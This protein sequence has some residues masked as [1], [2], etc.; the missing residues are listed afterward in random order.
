MTRLRVG[1]LAAFY[2]LQSTWVLHAGFDALFPR[3]AAVVTPDA[4]CA[5][6]C[7]CPEDVRQRG[8][9]C[10]DPLAKAAAPKSHASAFDVARCSGMDLAMAHAVGLPALLDVP[11]LLIV[12]AA[13]RGP[14]PPGLA[15]ALDVPALPLEKVPVA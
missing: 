7:G 13:E 10:C 14:L 5:S 15:P 8:D 2:L 11:R 1:V 9:C 3:V 12:A 4:C 6:S